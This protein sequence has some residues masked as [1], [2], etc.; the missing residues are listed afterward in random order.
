MSLYSEEYEPKKGVK[1]KGKNR[2][3]KAMNCQI[4]TRFLLWLLFVYVVRTT[5]GIILFCIS[6]ILDFFIILELIVP[7]SS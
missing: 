5:F 2:R 1:Y 7:F 4:R 3:G 6:L